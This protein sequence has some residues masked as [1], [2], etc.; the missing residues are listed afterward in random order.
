[1]KRRTL[2]VGVGS[3]VATSGAILQTSA[4]TTV[5]GDRGVSVDVADGSNAVVGIVGQGPVK[6]NTQLAMVEFTNNTEE[7]LT[8]TTTLDACTDGT[9][10]DNNGGSG[11]SV[12]ISIAPGS[13]RAVDIDAS[14]TGTISYGISVSSPSLSLTTDGTIQAESGNTVGAVRI[15]A[16]AKDNDFTASQGNGQNADEFQIK[17]VDVRDED[18]DTDLDRIEFEVEEG[19]T[20]GATV[21]SL[22]IDSPPGD[23]YSPNGNP[24]V[25]FPPDSGYSIKSNTTYA[26]TVTA[27]DADGNFQSVTIEDQT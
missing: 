18:G 14:V 27:S 19:G 5:S 15:Q 12:T 11:C 24:A 26:L 20:G 4:R 3:V 17:S 25:A 13:S 21:G 23:R 8:V 1:M 10:Y 2:L 7:T 16:P 22:T 9:L 6:K